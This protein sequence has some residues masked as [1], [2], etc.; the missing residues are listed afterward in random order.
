MSF[1][2]ILMIVPNAFLS[3]VIWLVILAALLYLAR[4]PVHRVILSASRG[5]HRALRLSA[6]SV[7]RAEDRLSQRNR[8]VLLASGRE[9]AERIVEREFDRIDDT[10]HRE[11][12]GYPEL[13]RRMG[14]EITAIEED[15]RNSSEVPPSPPGWTEAVDAVG[16]IPAKADPMVSNV[17]EDIHKSLVKAHEK[18]TTEYRKATSRRHKLLE[19][20]RPHWRRLQ[21]KV[22]HVDKN[23]ESLL[24]RSK[25]ID[26]QME[27]YEQTVNGTD[28]AVRMLSS[29]SLNQFFISLFVLLIAVGGATIN[30]YLIARPMAE[31]VGGTSSIA[32]Y[33]T[34]DIAALVII[35]VEV[36]MGLF[37]MESL[38][39]T[40]L[41]PVIG[42]LNDRQRHRMI[43]V[44][45]TILLALASVEAGLAYMR[46][47]LMQQELA[48]QAILS[49]E[50]GAA[51][52]GESIRWIT[53]AA[54]MG[55]GFILPFALVFVAIPLE[56][57]VQSLRT[58]LGLVG[59]GLLRVLAFTLRLLASG[60]RYLGQLL[61]DLYDL[62][63]FAPLWVEA[64]VSERGATPVSPALAGAGTGGASSS[65]AQ[66]RSATGG[67]RSRRSAAKS[68]PSNDSSGDESPGQAS[69]SQDTTG[70][71]PA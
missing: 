36:S 21:Q 29:S 39:I 14:E 40:R 4:S 59:V 38:R 43:G 33:R 2:D 48:T 41:F 45:F 15:H 66:S 1:S 57:F 18:A 63:I 3:V 34:A 56:T 65:G 47:I 9:A 61:V 26:R 23:V 69:S 12:A 68:A 13:H 35:F 27:E 42:A 28:R 30:F 22:N 54:Q 49:G 67:S 53:T 37:L 8:E 62:L 50:G 60:S 70:E 24:E 16:R 64:K 17:L 32:G 20:M 58:V 11:L 31:M 5:L 6:F 55:L 25:V 46:E 51:A 52:G 7:M 19:K 71:E 10:V 44:T